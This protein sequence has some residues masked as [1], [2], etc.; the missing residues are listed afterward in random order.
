MISE[1]DHNR[2]FK[3]SFKLISEKSMQ[4]P[5]NWV[6]SGRASPVPIST[7]KSELWASHFY[8]Q[9]VCHFLEEQTTA[10]LSWH[11]GIAWLAGRRSQQLHSRPYSA[12]WGTTH[13]ARY[14]VDGQTTYQWTLLRLES[15]AVKNQPSPYQKHSLKKVAKDIFGLKNPFKVL[16]D[17]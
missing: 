5:S 3:P 8:C 6:L 14:S 11:W 9:I 7:C 15:W 13:E 2:N 1:K 16:E 4:N 17:T 12:P 10:L